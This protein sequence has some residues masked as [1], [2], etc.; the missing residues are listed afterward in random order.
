MITKKIELIKDST[1]T[2]C[3]ACLNVCPV[4]AISMQEDER[5]FYKPKIN[6]SKC[7]D[8]GLCDKTCPILNENILNNISPELYALWANEKIRLLSSSGG[9]FTLF[10]EEIINRGGVVFGAAWSKDFSVVHQ[11]AE[12]L[13]E[14][15][16]LK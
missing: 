13:Q 6:L 7:I 9:A 4:G 1:C 8:C 5:G 15:E 11:K 2:G 3:M 16:L 12:N 14:L 10:A